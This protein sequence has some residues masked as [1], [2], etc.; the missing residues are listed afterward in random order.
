M[1]PRD[2]LARALL[3]GGYSFGAVDLSGAPTSAGADLDP[4][5]P[6]L[7]L[8]TPPVLGRAIQERLAAFVEA[9]GRLLLH[10]VLPSLDDDG[11]DCTVL[12]DALGLA[13][14]DPGRGHAAPLPVGAGHRRGRATSPRCGSASCSG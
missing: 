7:A 14:G 11:T 12:A 6:V 13:A 3:L 8:A 1:G 10:G 5:G 4:A 9:G 2:I